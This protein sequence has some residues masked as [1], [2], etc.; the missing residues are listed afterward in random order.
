MS[1]EPDIKAPAT[2][3][4]LKG[5]PTPKAGESERFFQRGFGRK[6]EILE[7]LNRD[8][9]SDLVVRIKSNG[10]LL[11]VGD[12]RF[13]MAQ[14]FGFCYGVD[15][16]VDYAYETRKQFPDRRIFIMTEIIHNP[17]VNKTL[18]VMGIEFL[19]G[20]CQTKTADDVTAEDV[21]ILPAFGVSVQQ[22]EEFR[23][24]GCILVDTTCGSVLNV[25]KRVEQYS[26]EGFTAVI[27]G[28]YSHEETIATSSRASLYPGGQY[29]VVRDMAQAQIVVDYIRHGGDKA[30]FLQIFE[31]AHAEGFDPDRHLQRVGIA[32]QTTMLSSESL[33]IARSL[34]DAIA[35]RFGEDEVKN[36]FRNF[37]TICSATQDR[38]DA[39]IKLVKEG[40]DIMIVVGGYNSSNTTH[41]CEIAEQHVPTYHIE[42]VNCIVSAAEIHHQPFGEHDTIVTTNW[43]PRA[44]EKPLTVG[45]TAGASTPDR[46]VGDVIERILSLRNLTVPPLPK[47]PTE[48]IVAGTV[49]PEE[50]AVA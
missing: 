34:R 26:R 27:H 33:A 37:E 39:I 23:K 30:K 41:L 9:H 36:R 7:E 13:R 2:S 16:A 35:E 3:Q 21:V 12:L 45:I 5:R 24:K 25:W 22:L 4:A 49:N 14:E 19:S 1:N 40:V 44:A 29:L 8:Y 32:N 48:V 38:Q 17:R 50:V 10:G 46:V 42:D 31:H 20:R 15:K 6:A 47:P 28:K 43:L 11:A 18:Q